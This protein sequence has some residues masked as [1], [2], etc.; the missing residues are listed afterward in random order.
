MFWILTLVSGLVPGMLLDRG[1]FVLGSVP[2]FVLLTGEGNL[3]IVLL[4]V[5]H[6]FAA[7]A[8]LE[9]EFCCH[10]YFSI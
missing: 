3:I 2:S 8:F 9:F 7:G 1:D 4:E 5:E 6:V 10:D